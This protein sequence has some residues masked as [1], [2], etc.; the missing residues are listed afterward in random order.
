MFVVHAIFITFITTPLV[1]LF[2][3]SKYRVHQRVDEAGPKA[4]ALPT[5]SDDTTKTRFALILDKIESLPAAMSLSQLL[6][7]PISSNNAIASTQY[8]N[9]KLG[10]ERDSVSEE[11]SVS[12]APRI[13]VE[14]LRLME[15]SN[16]TSAVLR[17]T[18]A[19]ALIYNDPVVATYRTFGEL[20]NFDVSASLSVVNFNEFPEAIASHVSS[21]RSEMVIIPWPRGAT[22]I[23]QEDDSPRIVL[24]ARNPFDGIFHKTT[25]EDQ[26]SS[27]V[28]SEFIRNVFSKTP[29][30]IAL[31]VD[32][33]GNEN[34]PVSGV[35]RRQHLFLAFIGGP[36]D[37]LALSFLVQ[38]CS[39]SNVSAT[40]VR[41][42]KTEPAPP[43]PSSADALELVS[44]HIPLVASTNATVRIFLAFC[45]NQ[46]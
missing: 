25:T 22:S 24:G 34:R 35:M 19:D 20:N 30:D 7:A 9:E 18:E 8:V 17:S 44:S 45:S 21:T 46:I 31:F 26:T 38:L 28:Y 16:R 32:R 39:R 13:T 36:D 11:N 37:R 15:L 10:A 3:P 14:A 29:S 6:Q 27:F 41:L 5:S 42:V 4:A 1:L 23:H 2:Y 40:V 12:P 33:G 43:A